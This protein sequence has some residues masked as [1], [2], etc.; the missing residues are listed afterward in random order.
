MKQTALPASEDGVGGLVLAAG[1]GRRLRPL[2]CT[3]PKALVPF[4]G[5]PLLELAVRQLARVKDLD[6]DPARTFALRK[7]VD[8]LSRH[9][10]AGVRQGAIRSV[11]ACDRLQTEELL[12]RLREMADADPDARIRILAARTLERLGR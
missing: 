1:E 11:G 3:C 7:A 4:A 2:T 8:A 10:V 12:A 5:V 9:V 6:L